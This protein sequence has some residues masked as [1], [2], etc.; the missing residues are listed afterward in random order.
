[1]EVLLLHKRK[2]I[3]HLHISFDHEAHQ[4][5]AICDTRKKPVALHDN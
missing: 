5:V 2:D 1:M 4:P 3:L